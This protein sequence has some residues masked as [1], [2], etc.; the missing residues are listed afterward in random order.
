M[1]T[2]M[3]SI[4]RSRAFAATAHVGAMELK[5]PGSLVDQM[6]PR[7]LGSLDDYQS[8]ARHSRQY[9]LLH[10]W[11]YSVINAVA[12]SAAGQPVSLGRLI[13]APSPA[14]ERRTPARVT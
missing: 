1:K 6:T 10:G 5:E 8:R 9:G 11:I 3:K 13:E 12:E 4:E 14:R 7:S 2:L